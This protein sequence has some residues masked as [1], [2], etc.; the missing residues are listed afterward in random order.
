MEEDLSV[1]Q[2][3]S[4]SGGSVRGG[5]DP[6]WHMVSDIVRFRRDDR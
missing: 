3:H 5:V 6:G 2:P 4:G 1:A